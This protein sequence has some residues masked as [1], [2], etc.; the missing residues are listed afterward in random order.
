MFTAVFFDHNNLETFVST[1]KY[2]YL[3][4]NLSQ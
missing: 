4:G 1:L 3:E 2:P